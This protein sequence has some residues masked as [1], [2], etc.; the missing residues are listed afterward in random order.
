MN[1]GLIGE[2]TRR[3]ANYV[4]AVTEDKIMFKSWL[5]DLIEVSDKTKKE[6]GTP[7]YTEYTASK[8]A[9]QWPI[10]NKLRQQYRKNYRKS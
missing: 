9:G 6:F 1:H 5:K 3:G 2:I 4:I 8:V 7:E 10:I